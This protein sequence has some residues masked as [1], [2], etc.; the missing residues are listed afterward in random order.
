MSAQTRPP[1]PTPHDAA[2]DA[3]RSTVPLSVYRELTG[4]LR[5]TRAKLDSLKQYNQ[6][7]VE[8]NRRLQ[9]ELAAWREGEPSAAEDTEAGAANATPPSPQPPAFAQPSL[10]AEQW[11]AAE[12]PSA[13]SSAP[14]EGRTAGMSV[15]GIAITVSLIALTCFGLGFAIV[16]PLL[17]DRD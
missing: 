13:P 15:W 4:E 14:S 9:Q 2:S 3:S 5:A 16:Y 11:V 7:L 6:Q 8:R 1:Q 17:G 12:P 10:P